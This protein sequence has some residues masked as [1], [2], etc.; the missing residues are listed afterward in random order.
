MSQ[1]DPNEINRLI[2][3]F[4]DLQEQWERDPQ[5]FDWTALEALA[6]RGA[7]AYNEGCGPSFH[8]LALD[9]TLHGEFH[10]RFLA[11]SL[12][13]GF[14]PFKLAR[15]GAGPEEIPVIDHG[16]LAEQARSNPCSA[17]MRASLMELARPRFEPLAQDIE[18]GK[19][20]ASLWLF[21]VAEACA[22]SVPLDLLERISPELA[23]AHH[24]EA[25][26]QKVDPVEG[27]LSEAEV[28]VSARS[29]PYG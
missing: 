7:Q 25:R 12:Q 13:A 1:S 19:P 3:T 27:Y 4:T 11:Y 28:I 2:G 15:A 29:E 6:Q 17:R 24:G 5:A 14:D 9:G 22:E 8:A 20:A 16:V 26:K 23:R 18:K 10:E 21:R